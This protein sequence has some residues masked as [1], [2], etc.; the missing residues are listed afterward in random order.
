MWTGSV[1]TTFVESV[2]PMVLGSS[3]ASFSSLASASRSCFNSA[4]TLVGYWLSAFFGTSLRPL[5]VTRDLLAVA[6]SFAM[7]A[8]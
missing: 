2:T 4:M 1:F 5:S 8:F 7:A 3:G 6:T